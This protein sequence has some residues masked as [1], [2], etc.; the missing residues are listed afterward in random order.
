MRISRRTVAAAAACLS[1]TGCVDARSGASGAADA[2]RRA[3]QTP[4]RIPISFEPAAPGGSARFVG[5]TT[6][7]ALRLTAR[8]ATLTPNADGE[9]A[10]RLELLGARPGARPAGRDR[11]QGVINRYHGADHRRWRTNIP[12]YGRVRYDRVWNG[13]DVDFHG[14]NDVLEYDLIVRPGADPRDV[15]LR[16]SGTPKLDRRG[17][18][19]IP[20]KSGRYVQGRPHI[21]QRIKGRRVVV[22]GRYIVRDRE[23]GVSVGDYDRSHTLVIDPTL[24]YSRF[25]GGNGAD[26]LND[27]DVGPDGTFVVAGASTST[28]LQSEDQQA[29]DSDAYIAKFNADGSL[30]YATYLG[31]PAFDAAN[32]VA[33]DAAGAVALAGQTSGIGFPTVDP[34][35]PLGYRGG[36]DAFLVL[37]S[38]SGTVTTSTYIGG[39]GTDIA[40]DVEI[41]AGGYVYVVGQTSSS[42]L[43][44]A[45]GGDATLGGSQDGFVTRYNT[46]GGAVG[47]ASF[48][49]GNYIGGSGVDSATAVAA[50]TVDATAAR[51][52]VIVGTSTSGGLDFGQPGGTQTVN[53]GG[54]DAFIRYNNGTTS[55][56]TW[57]TF[58]GGNGTDTAT[59]VTVSGGKVFVTGS[60]T[61]SNMPLVAAFKGSLGGAGDAFVGRFAFDTGAREVSTYLGSAD[62]EGATG[63][64]V[65]ATSGQVWLAGTTLVCPPFVPEC[66]PNE[67]VTVW[68]L[69]P[70]ATAIRETA[71]VTPASDGG[72]ID[73]ANG[74][75][76]GPD[77][78]PWVVGVTASDG[79]PTTAGSGDTT[80]SVGNDGFISRFDDGTTPDTTIDSGPAAAINTTSATFTFSA[81]PAEPGTFECQLD[82]AAYESCTSPRLLT[83]LSEATHTFRVRAVNVSETAD[84]TP[85][86][87]TFRV[88]TT[89]PVVTIIDRPAQQARGPQHEVSFVAGEDATFRCSVDGGPEEACVRPF[90]VATPTTGERVVRI[91]ATDVA[92]NDSAPVEVSFNVFS[93]LAEIPDTEIFSGPQGTVPPGTATFGFTAKPAEPGV[94]Y[95][96]SMDGQPFQRCVAP[97]SYDGLPNGLHT[98][99]VRV[100]DA[101]GEV[102]ATPAE[103]AFFIAEPPPAPPEAAAPVARINPPGPNVPLGADVLF[104]AFPSEGA[105]LSY[106]WDLDGDGVFEAT[107]RRVTQRYFEPGPRRAQLRVTD[108]RS[109]RAETDTTFTVATPGEVRLRYTPSLPKAGQ[110]IDFVVDRGALSKDE[111]TWHTGADD[112]PDGDGSGR[113]GGRTTGNRV[114]GL[115]V[116]NGAITT[117]NKLSQRY[118]KSGRYNL[119]VT[120]PAGDGTG[121]TVAQSVPVGSS[122]SASQEFYSGFTL[123][124]TVSPGQ[125]IQIADLSRVGSGPSYR[126]PAVSFA[127]GKPVNAERASVADQGTVSFTI[128]GRSCGEQCSTTFGGSVPVTF[129]TPGTYTVTMTAKRASAK[130]SAVPGPKPVGV[131]RYPA[132][133]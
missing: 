51:D 73:R 58:H 114:P 46:N 42:N 63:I 69:A 11:L 5:H 94:A 15:R 117:D 116:A 7:Q 17:R 87:S 79:Y 36:D 53:G 97:Q 101:A 81:S 80:K 41:T 107:G 86:Q 111:H 38:S 10:L 75:D 18:L 99:K 71:I 98:F 91:R 59:A 55:T 90:A 49:Q 28:D 115:V 44:T 78:D 66:I 89:P 96:C 102:D 65:S 109:R 47:V 68:R 84:P 74:L 128:N 83:G 122:V 124:S 92:G 106:E 133:W 1:I 60:T 62:Y 45:G 21:F 77:G 130:S 82:V 52:A 35:H 121:V 20:G 30:M 113:D 125:P 22:P 9:P 54:Q 39:S 8:G 126:G 110:T 103:R 123:P 105:G 37:L 27:I 85:A 19:V 132:A 61:S 104:D 93:V 40:N 24:V 119:Q 16:L 14:R 72:E 70:G 50:D 2:E 31:S 131:A 67:Q 100:L 3:G 76:T 57:G 33:M 29:G 26:T 4:T 118:G 43:P 64:G 127:D 25:L 108:N 34:A 88:D 112:D 32:G 129:D 13:I 56:T 95:E 12:T 6:G 120:S 23:I 48:V